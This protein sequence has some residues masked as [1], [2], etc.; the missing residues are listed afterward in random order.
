LDTSLPDAKTFFA[1]LRLPAATLLPLV[2]FVVACFDGL[3]SAAALAVRLEPRHR[4]HLVRFLARQGWA[5]DW[6]CL[7]TLADRVL[8]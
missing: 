8:R 7:A 5:R 6:P 4:A 3:R 2:R 1:P